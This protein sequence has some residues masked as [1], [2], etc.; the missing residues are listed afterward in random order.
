MTITGTSRSRKVLGGRIRVVVCA[1]LLVCPAV[2]R[3][4][5]ARADDPITYEVV[6]DS[7][8]VATVEWQD[9]AGRQAMQ[10]VTLPWRMDVS[11]SDPLAQPPSGSQVRAD[12]RPGAAPG[13]WVSVR[14][15]YKGKVI[16]QNTLDI[17]DAAC[18]G[19]T[20]RV[21]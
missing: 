9:A 18:Y 14:I 20:R 7:I 12:W 19:S 5:A 13:R 11:M 8:G 1:A 4:A 15:T 21:T 16:C 2:G 17:G 6:S 3:P 10:D